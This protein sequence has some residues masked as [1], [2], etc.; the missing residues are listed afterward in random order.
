MHAVQLSSCLA[1]ACAAGRL[2][3]W[4]RQG[5]GLKGTAAAAAEK[6]PACQ[7]EHCVAYAGLGAA[8][9]GY[10][11]AAA[12]DGC[13]ACCDLKG[14]TL[15]LVAGAGADGAVAACATACYCPL[16]RNQLCLWQQC[17]EGGQVAT[18]LPLP[19]VVT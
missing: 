11:G 17:P 9:A 16:S 13:T 3:R 7:G 10:A 8:A 18:A 5:T 6:V 19:L 4:G 14:G 12:A 2:L 15:Q 1:A